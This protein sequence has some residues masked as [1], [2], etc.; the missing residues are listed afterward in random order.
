[1]A[2]EAGY[3]PVALTFDYGQRH[4]RELESAT[5]VAAAIGVKEHIVLPLEIGGLLKSS[6]TRKGIAV[7]K[8]RSEREISSGVP[9]TYVPSR[10]IIFLSIAAS[11][12]ESRGAAAIFIAVNSVDFSGYPDCTPQFIEAFQRVLDVG[13]KA[14]VEGR[15]IKIEAPL[16]S[17]SKADIV[18]K[19]SRLKVPLDLTWSCYEGG[20]KACG[21]CDSCQLRRKGFS[22]AGLKD[23]VEYEVK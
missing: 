9:S 10:N 18:R 6:L 19:A 1:M 23:P 16:L 13:T 11:I 5:R 3:D 21:K 15:A 4:G 12:A 22:E 7:P 17:L 2:K 20:K 14:G 8:G